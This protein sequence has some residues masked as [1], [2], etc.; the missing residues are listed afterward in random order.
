MEN[1]GF[2]LRVVHDSSEPMERIYSC[3]TIAGTITG[4]EIQ[5]IVDWWC[6]TG[7]M[8]AGDGEFCRGMW[9]KPVPKPHMTADQIT[10]LAKRCASSAWDM[11]SD[12]EMAMPD[13][14][15]AYEVVREMEA[16]D[17]NGDFQDA[18]FDALELYPQDWPLFKLT[19]K[20]HYESLRDAAKPVTQIQPTL[21][22]WLL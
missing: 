8:D 3:P 5:A 12:Y 17:A 15:S 2:K 16:L 4:E 21:E 1:T 11:A 20:A 7:S 14:E 13:A 19:Y 18:L 22:Y 9:V 10:D 6:G